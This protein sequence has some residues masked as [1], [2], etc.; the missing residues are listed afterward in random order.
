[1]S[2]SSSDPQG[3]PLT[4]AAAA[5][6]TL[7]V[8]FLDA[9]F[10]GMTEAGRE[11]AYLDLVSRTGCVALAYSVVFF[12]ILRLHEPETSIRHVLALRA[13]SVVALML[14]VVVGIAMSLPAEWLG[15]LME[16]RLPRSDQEQENFDRLYSVATTG[17]RVSLVIS[18]VCI[19]PILDELY[20][21]GAIFTPLRRTRRWETVVLATAAFETLRSG[22]PRSMM[23]VLVVS[24]VFAWIRAATGSVFPSILARMSFVAVGVIPMVMGRDLPKPTLAWLAGTTLLAVGGLLGLGL[25][26]RRNA[27]LHLADDAESL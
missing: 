8:V 12:G 25:L 18:A 5:L 20:F 11:G 13:P 7:L 22:S 4:F 17:K 6:W 15:Q 10:I 21:R 2:S 14:V 16:L 23:I 19:Q 1:M 26:S 3:R 24:L 9:F 27:H